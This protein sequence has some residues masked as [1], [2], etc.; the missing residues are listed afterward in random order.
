MRLFSLTHLCLFS[1]GSGGHADVPEPESE[2]QG[3]EVRG[4]FEEKHGRADSCKFQ[5]NGERARPFPAESP[6]VSVSLIPC[7]RH[8]EALAPYQHIEQDLKSLKEVVEM[9]NQQIHQQEKKITDLEKVV[10]SNNL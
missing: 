3:Q 9:K 6:S 1:S 2:G 7:S 10:G 4:G 5:S 8:Q